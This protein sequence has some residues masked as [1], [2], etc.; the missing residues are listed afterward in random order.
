ML[1]ATLTVLV[2]APSAGAA[3]VTDVVISAGRDDVGSYT[4]KTWRPGYPLVTDASNFGPAGTVTVSSLAVKPDAAEINAGYLGDVHVLFDGWVWDI[5]S[6]NSGPTWSQAELDA[7]D[8]WVNAGGVLI[9]NED[10]PDAD[11]LAEMYGLSV[12]VPTWTDGPDPDELPDDPNCCDVGDLGMITPVAGATGHPIVDSGGSAFG[13]W[14]SINPGGTAGHFGPTGSL[15]APWTAIAENRN[16]DVSVATRAVGAGFVILTGDEGFFRENL[17]AGENETFLL[18]VFAYAIS[19]TDDA[20]TFPLGVVGPGDQPVLVSAVD[21]LAMSTT[22]GDGSAITWS[23]TALPIGLSIA[24][25]TGIISGTPTVVGTTEVT[26]TA[27]PLTGT[28]DSVTFDYIVNSGLAIGDPG[29]QESGIDVAI[30]SLE[31]STTGGD[32]SAIIWSVDQLPS[33]LTLSSDGFISGTPDTVGT[34]VVTVTATQSTGTPG[35]VTFDWV[36][37]NDISLTDPGDQMSLISVPVNL[38]LATTAGDGSSVSFAA[39]GLPAGLAIDTGTGAI[40]GTPTALGTSMVTLTAS[41]N[42]GSSQVMI[43][44]AVTQDLVP[45]AGD[46]TVIGTVG[47]PLSTSL[48]TNDTEG[49]GS[50][51]LAPTGPMPPGLTLSS[52]LLAGTPTEAGEFSFTYILTDEDNDQS[53]AATVTVTI[54]AQPDPVF[55][56]GVEATIV[57]TSGNDTLTGTEG[58]DVIAGLGGQ[59][60]IRGLGGNDLICGNGGQD[61]ISGGKGADTIFGGNKADTIS[62]NGG[63]DTISGGKGADT[64]FG[65]NRADT[66]SGNGGQDTISGGKGADIINGGKK[67]DTLSGKSGNDTL[68]GNGGADEL[69]GGSGTDTCEGGAGIDTLTSCEA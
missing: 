63:Q 13:A 7:I 50:N 36:V 30:D 38:A 8:D 52:C 23:S 4:L 3:P 49:E 1:L 60:E 58:I 20:N 18:N 26:V 44:W 51:T 47:Q 54:S 69:M 56:N 43:D 2:P 68:R 45:I 11:E 64:I 37:V 62:G 57:G 42:S 35:M 14:T 25:G 29:D 9:A 39:S 48:C 59:D 66:I 6:G 65:G 15:P 10:D 19:L 5:T 12:T 33:G 41:D 34:T 28:P 46:D 31:L 32:G 24:P 61:T 16:G 67:A 21:S 53:N 27:T 22:G 17:V 55:C 40:S